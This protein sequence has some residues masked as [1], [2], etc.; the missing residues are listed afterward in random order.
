V[1]HIAIVDDDERSIEVVLRH[2]RRY[3][4]EHST[5]F[6]VRT[7]TDGR[8]FVRGYRSDLDVLFLDV[9]MPTMDGFQVAHTIRAL[10]ER[11][12][13]VFITQMGQLA[14]RGYEVGALSYLVKPTPYSAFAHEL[15]R[16]LQ[17]VRLSVAPHLMVPSA[18]GVARLDTADIVYVESSKHRITVHTVDEG[19]T[20]T[21]TLKAVESRLDEAGFFRTSSSFL[22][23]LRHVVAVHRSACVVAG[24]HEVPISRA[25]KR[26]FLEAMTDHLGGRVC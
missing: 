1:H 22:V 21:G 12:V 25:R 10:D 3:Q 18:R 9:E 24:G 15:A 17:R 7:F 26:D 11:V 13:I 2:L 6:T 20:F 16:G 19:H 4:D 5:K 23:N 14:I 8:D